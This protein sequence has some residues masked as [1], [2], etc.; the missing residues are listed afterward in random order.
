MGIRLPNPS[1]WARDLREHNH[2]LGELLASV[3]DRLCQHGV[4]LLLAES[5]GRLPLHCVPRHLP[6]DW[7][8]AGSRRGRPQLRARPY[9][10]R[11]CGRLVA[12]LQAQTGQHAA[13]R[14]TTAPETTRNLRRALSCGPEPVE[15]RYVFRIPA[16]ERYYSADFRTPPSSLCLGPAPPAGRPP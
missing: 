5:L 12:A 3:S 15:E 7:T 11:C 13:D 9:L 16:H 6:C 10:G 1:N 2:I 8:G 14:I 4:E